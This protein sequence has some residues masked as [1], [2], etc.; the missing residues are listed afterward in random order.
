M[1][2]KISEAKILNLYENGEYFKENFPKPCFWVQNEIKFQKTSKNP[3]FC[4]LISERFSR[5]F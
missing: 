3:Y 5:N 1:I 4:Y 2:R